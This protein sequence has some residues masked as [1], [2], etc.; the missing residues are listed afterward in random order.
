MADLESRIVEAARDLIR[1]Q[2]RELHLEPFFNVLENAVS[3]ASDDEF[4]EWC[5]Q[6]D[7]IVSKCMGDRGID[8]ERRMEWDYSAHFN[9]GLTRAEGADRLYQFLLEAEQ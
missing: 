1:A 4:D 3:Q 6:V 9:E 8:E 5:A 7:E 2:K